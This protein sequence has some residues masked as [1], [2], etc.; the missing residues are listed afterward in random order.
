MYY[1]ESGVNCGVFGAVSFRWRLRRLIFSAI[2]AHVHL[3]GEEATHT[4]AD[5]VDYLY[6]REHSENKGYLLKLYKVAIDVLFMVDERVNGHL[7]G[8]GHSP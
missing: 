5:P 8:V 6:L 4:H 7:L 1:D 2:T 3:L